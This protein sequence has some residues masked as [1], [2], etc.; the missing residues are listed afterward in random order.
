MTAQENAALCGTASNATFATG[1]FAGTRFSGAGNIVPGQ[2]LL[3]IGRRDLEGGNRIDD[4]RHTAYRV[5][6]GAK[7][8]LGS[9]WSYDVYGQYGITLYTETYDNEFSVQRTQNALQVD[10]TTHQC[11]ALASD[12]SCVPLDIF[13]GFGAITPGMLNYVEAQGFK[14]GYTEEMVIDGSMTGDL[15]QYGVKAPWAKDGAGVAFGAEYR[16]ESLEL[17]T[18]RDFQTNDLYG[19]AARRFPCRCRRST[20][21]KASPKFASRSSRTC[22]S[23]KTS[24]STPLRASPPTARPARCGRT[25]PI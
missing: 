19:R 21:R 12:S 6:V 1:P 13:N 3:E 10:P 4:L 20:L 14:Q 11:I 25:R 22:R 8:D 5:V 24:P 7:G 15:G 2:A 16:K 17:K 9:A 18:S 23:P